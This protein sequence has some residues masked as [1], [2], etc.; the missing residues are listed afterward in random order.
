MFSPK[1]LMK[2]TESVASMMLQIDAMKKRITHLEY[3]FKTKTDNSRAKKSG[4][5][6]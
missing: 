5:A 3:Q 2:L 1:D 4:G 6:K